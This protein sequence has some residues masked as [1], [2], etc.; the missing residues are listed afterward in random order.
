MKRTFARLLTALIAAAILAGLVYLTLRVTHVSEPAP[1]TV[2]APT[3]RRLVATAAAV[4]ALV[5]AT[6][7]GLALARPTGCFGAARGGL[8]AVVAGTA[9]SVNGGLIL[10]FAQGGL[11]S[12]NGVVGGAVAVVLGVIAVG[13]GGTALARS[14]G[15]V[16]RTARP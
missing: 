12:G 6:V 11:G 4:L 5:G 3:M 8:G 13:L 15:A 7:G 2:H 14:R 10:A 9:A 1:T 16:R